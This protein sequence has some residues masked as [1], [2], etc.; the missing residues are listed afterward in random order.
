MTET[1]VLADQDR[2][3][4]EQ[5]V[6]T[7]LAK[8]WDSLRDLMGERVRLRGLLPS[9]VQEAIGPDRA[10]H[11]MGLWL[12]PD[13]HIEE[14]ESLEVV[15]IQSR[16]RA[17]YRFKVRAGDT[18]YVCEQSAFVTVEEGKVSRFDMLCSGFLP[19]S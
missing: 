6:H 13:D 14:I 10:I 2:V 7:F 9:M 1:K 16:H 17:T 4:V 11:F 5:F 18:R 12:E 19:I 8:D 15:P 3:I